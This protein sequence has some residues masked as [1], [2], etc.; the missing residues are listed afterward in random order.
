MVGRESLTARLAHH[1][2]LLLV[3][4][5]LIVAHELILQE[6]SHGHHPHDRHTRE[7]TIETLAQEA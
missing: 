5:L 1:N 3:G 7:K 4:D 6:S 2:Q